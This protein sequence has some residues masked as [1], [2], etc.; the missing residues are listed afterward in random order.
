M[1]RVIYVFTACAGL[2]F[3][4]ACNETTNTD[5]PEI[6]TSQDLAVADISTETSEMY[7]YVTAGSGLSLREFNNLSS[8]KLAVMPY[9]TKLMVLEREDLATMTVAG[10]KGA[11]HEVEFN[12]KKGYAFSGYLSRFF[13]PE[14]DIRSVVYAEDLQKHFPMVTFAETTG[15][16][17]SKPTNTETLV[18]PTQQWHE[19]FFIAQRLHDIPKAF[20][21]P[22]PKGRDVQLIKNNKPSP[23][24]WVSELEVTRDK[25]VFQK[26][27]YRY[28]GE[29]YASQVTITKE[30]EMMKIEHHSIAN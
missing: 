22:N 19:A 25:D 27:M 2:F 11:M 17:A 29:G 14:E 21:F 15:G 3:L 28:A 24:L 6:D 10:M 13:P 20:A 4:N 18:L 1:K 5:T 8:E 16:T 7:L 30:G 26:I 23:R 12:H 9:G